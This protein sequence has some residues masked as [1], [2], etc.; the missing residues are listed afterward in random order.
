LDT[1]RLRPFD[2]SK[3]NKTFRIKFHDANGDLEIQSKFIWKRNHMMHTAIW[4]FN[5][6]QASITKKKQGVW[7]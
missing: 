1:V 4:R 6:T 2:I 3:G 5:H 7:T